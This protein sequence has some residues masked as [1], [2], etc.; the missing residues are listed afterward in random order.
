MA[1]IPDDRNLGRRPVA[2]PSRGRA[3]LQVAATGLAEAANTQAQV[4]TVPARTLQVGSQV[5]EAF[6][7]AEDRIRSRDDTV[8][9]AREASALSLNVAEEWRRIQDEEDLSNRETAG[10]FIQFLNTSVHDAVANHSGSA[11]SKAILATQTERLRTQYTNLAATGRVEAGKAVVND[12][13]QT[14]ANS[15]A[16]DAYSTPSQFNSLINDWYKQVDGMQDA[17]TV[18]DDLEWRRSG[19]SGIASNAVESYLDS[20]D[21]RTALRLMRDP[22]VSGLLSPADRERLG[23]RAITIQQG[24]DADNPVLEARQRRQYLTALL[25]RE[26]T[27]DE[28]LTDEGMN[29]PI[30]PAARLEQDRDA[31]IS[32]GRYSDAGEIQDVITKMGTVTGRT[33]EDLSQTQT[34]EQVLLEPTPEDITRLRTHFRENQGS[35][36]TARDTLSSVTEAGGF[37][38]GALGAV[39]ESVT[40]TLGQLGTFGEFFNEAFEKATGAEREKLTDARTRMREGVASQLSEIT[41]EESGRF[42]K[43][44]RQLANEVLAGLTA[45]ADI[46]R[47]IQ[48]YTTYMTILNASDVRHAREIVQNSGI[49][50]RT[51]DGINRLGNT[52]RQLGTSEDRIFEILETPGFLP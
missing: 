5:A 46:D 45:S 43:D 18:G 6:Q 24:L 27:E 26:P 10:K 34:F 14:I 51:P 29:P 48:A 52:L 42:T 19:A 49:D 1:K 7:V 12:T 32:E 41:E 44:E 15:I 4:A 35:F 38:V 40:G 11:D 22:T 3:N 25:G 16:G 20:G 47:V 36:E 21:W 23:G 33:P 31:A 2:A 8:S 30:S 13:M 39:T 28:L 17:L 50:L 9:R 37:A